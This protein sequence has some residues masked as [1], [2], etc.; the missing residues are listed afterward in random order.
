MEKRFV[1]IDDLNIIQNDKDMI[2]IS[3]D[4]QLSA[5]GTPFFIM[6]K[7]DI[8]MCEKIFGGTEDRI[9]YANYYLKHFVLNKEIFYFLESEGFITQRLDF[10]YFLNRIFNLR[11]QFI[12]GI[13]AVAMPN[14]QS[15]DPRGP[16]SPIILTGLDSMLIFRHILYRKLGLNAKQFESLYPLSEFKDEINV[17]I[18]RYS[19][20]MK[21]EKISNNN[22][23]KLILSETE[24]LVN[25]LLISNEHYMLIR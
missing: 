11:K 4:L 25:N 19:D 24:T 8:N 5:A 7:I 20:N 10:E 22:N 6:S 3:L 13:T 2:K 14:I 15:I 17:Y 16:D 21:N 1:N 9:K 18:E 23:L 12:L